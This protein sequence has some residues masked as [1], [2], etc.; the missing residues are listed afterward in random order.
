MEGLEGSYRVSQVAF[1]TDGTPAATPKGSPVGAIACLTA[2][3][4]VR[5]IVNVKDCG[6]FGRPQFDMG[7]VG[8]IFFTRLG[9]LTHNEQRM[10]RDA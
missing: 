8:F 2:F 5:T 1:P 7:N 9:L 3:R 4:S 10:A 6:F